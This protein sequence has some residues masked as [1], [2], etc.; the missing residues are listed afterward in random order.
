M[1]RKR[2]AAA[3]PSSAL[4]SAEHFPGAREEQA[5]DASGSRDAADTNQLVVTAADVAARK[6][7]AQE[8]LTQE[9]VQGMLLAQLAKAVC[10]GLPLVI[11]L[12]PCP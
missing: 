4:L 8:A 7:Q 9:A 5:L 3:A 6:R 10:R 12:R 1:G 2:P 11:D